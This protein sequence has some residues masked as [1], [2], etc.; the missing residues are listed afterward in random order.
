[1]TIIEVASDKL[2]GRGVFVNPP[3]YVNYPHAKRMNS[4][5]RVRNEW[6]E[7]FIITGFY[8]DFQKYRFL[9]NRRPN[10]SIHNDP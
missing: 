9:K 6:T 4:T 2:R 3:H 1:M 5:I 8:A 7:S 10:L